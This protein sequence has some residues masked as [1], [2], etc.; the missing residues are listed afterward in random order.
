MGMFLYGVS[1][2]ATRAAR[3]V[4]DYAQQCVRYHRPFEK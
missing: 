1:T 4:I 2:L 3:M